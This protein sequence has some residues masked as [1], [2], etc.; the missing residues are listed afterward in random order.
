[1]SDEP[2]TPTPSEE[3]ELVA[4]R[5]A[6]EELRRE[7]RVRFKGDR[8]DA[9]DALPAFDELFGELRRRVARIGMSERSGEVDEFGMDE[10]VLR[11]ARGVLDFLFERYWRVDLGGIERLPSD[12]PVLLVA[13][14]S[15]L[16]PY[17]GV[18][19]AHCVERFRGELGRPRSS[20]P[21]RR[22]VW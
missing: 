1:M 5:E 3:R 18:M 15:G 21:L 8:E 14:R 10:A 13:N 7:I 16:L 17:D 6:L 22:A 20:P 12:G 11:R 19:I 2:P 4:V 9:P